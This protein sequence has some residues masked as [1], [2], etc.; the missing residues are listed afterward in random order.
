MNMPLI[1]LVRV[2]LLCGTALFFT[3]TFSSAE[4]RIAIGYDYAIR[5]GD[6]NFA[7]FILPTG[8]GDNRYNL[9]LFNGTEYIFKEQVTGGIPYIFDPGGVDRFR[10]LGIE[11]SAGVDPD[12]PEAFMT[13]LAWVEDCECTETEHGI[14][15]TVFSDIPIGYWADDSIMTIYGAG[16]TTG[17]SQNPLMY[18]P[19]DNV[20]REQMAVFITRALNQVP[21]DGYCGTTNPFSDVGFGR[22]S[23]KYIRRL[24]ELGISSGYGD[25]RFGPEDSVTREQM[26]VFLTRALDMVPE[27]GYC[28]VTNPFTDVAYDR[29]SCKN[30]KRLAELGITTGYGDGRFGPDA[31]VT[32]DQMAVFLSRALAVREQQ[33]E[34]STT[35]YCGLAGGEL[36]VTDPSSCAYGV[37]I[38]IPPGALDV[39]GDERRSFSIVDDPDYGLAPPLPPGFI[40]HPNQFN[41]CGFALD[42]GGDLPYNV[43]L[44][45]YFPIQGMTIESGEM[46]FAFAYDERL[47]KWSLVLPESIG[48][49]TMT[50]KANYRRVWKW[51]KIVFNQV[52]KEYLVQVIEEKYGADTWKV[53]LAR[54][55]ELYNNLKGQQVERTCAS[56]IN[57]RD[58]FFEDWKQAFRP[59]LLEYQAQFGACGACDVLSEQ[60]S[61]DIFTYISNR[62]EVEMWELL[63]QVAGDKELAVLYC[64]FKQL[65]A[66]DEI[67]KLGCSP[68]CVTDVGGIDFWI[69][70]A[71]YYM[72]VF[73]QQLINLAIEQGWVT[74]P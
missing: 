35:G 59:R 26:A 61:K 3:P 62:L 70:Y 20:T 41:P 49:S 12:D 16:I 43:E 64:L 1:F 37:R 23:C 4:P 63:E 47:G 18:C 38:V 24:A 53:I 44:Y 31:Y 22:W 45:F 55:D 42:T 39:V 6:P 8:I 28:R 13:L 5:P 66:W 2:I 48:G 14:I 40:G 27:E 32:R 15:Q 60:F 7:A 71:S 50:V 30:I 34:C 19:G 36:S 67:A 65:Q 68:T 73:G 9:Y 57:L 54:I 25:G 52:P 58:G 29:W 33:I 69:D 72:G 10:I 17:C 21:A 74:C 56:L 51:G 46:A 11:A